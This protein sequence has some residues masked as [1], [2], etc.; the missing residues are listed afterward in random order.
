MGHFQLAIEPD[1][2][3][4][5]RLLEFDQKLGRDGQLAQRDHREKV[6]HL[7]GHA[8]SLLL[9]AEKQKFEAD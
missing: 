6:V 2:I 9:E 1:N 8:L 4:Q 7:E 5:L 3:G